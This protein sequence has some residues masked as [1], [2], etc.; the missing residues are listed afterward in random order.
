MAVKL[1]KLQADT[2]GEH[3]ETAVTNAA[4]AP[5]CA[6]TTPAIAGTKEPRN[7]KERGVETNGRGQDRLLALSLAPWSCVLASETIE[8]GRNR[9][10]TVSR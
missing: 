4:P 7:I 8:R 1:D 6:I 10:D 5:N 2:E 9:S 3:A